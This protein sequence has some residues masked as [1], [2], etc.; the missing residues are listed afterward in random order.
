MAARKHPRRYFGNVRTLPSGRFQARYTGPDGRTYKAP[1][2]FDTKGDAE[3]WLSVRQSE[4]VRGAWLP[5]AEPKADPVTLRAYAEAWLAGRDLKPRTRRHYR[6][7]LD[8]HVLPAL[9]DLAVTEIRPATVRAWHSGL[10]P[11]R[12]TM[13]AHAYSLLRTI[14]HTAVDDELIPA[15]PCRVRS[16][17]GSK[18]A[19]AIR[20]ATLD[21]LVTITTEMPAQLRLMV[22]LAA[23][24]ALRFGELAEMRRKDVDVRNGVLRVRRGVTYVGGER[25]VAEPK[26]DSKRDVN[27]PPHLMPAVK[28]HLREH[29]PAERDGLLFRDAHGRQLAPSSLYHHYWRARDKAGRPD[30]R[31]HDLRHTG[32]VLAA[33][34]GATLAELMARLG[35]STPSAA[36]RYQ[37]AAQDRDKAIAKALSKLATVTSLDE[38]KKAAKKSTT[39]RKRKGA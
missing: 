39:R 22:P 15:N 34:T 26:A 7:L 8:A 37:H 17:G 14:L 35:H 10:C 38:G 11:G 9:G 18:R 29:V 19:R 21:E 16:A 1:V 25:V 24:C 5:P 2:T 3:A 31:F 13:R 20:P 6:N 30:L 4:I 36:M 23:W 28:A 33:A 27:V 12:P 32:A